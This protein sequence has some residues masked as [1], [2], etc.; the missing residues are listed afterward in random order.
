MLVEIERQRRIDQLTGV[1]NRVGFLER[2]DEE[3]K[4]A[5][6]HCGHLSLL[7]V[8]IQGLG[9]INA[10]HGY[11][12]GNAVL[13]RVV[14]LCN[15]QLRSGDVVARIGG[16][17]LGILLPRTPA[18]GAQIVVDA[19]KRKIEAEAATVGPATIPLRVEIGAASAAHGA[20]T[21]TLFESAGSDLEARKAPPASDIAA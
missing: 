15:V 20:D 17:E 18:E 21:E 12:S 3:C 9:E 7:R 19:L 16:D 4:A 11:A 2:L 13:L 14:G 1:A 6:R 8:E 10:T 5:R